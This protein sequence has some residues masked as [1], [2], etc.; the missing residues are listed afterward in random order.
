MGI[1]QSVTIYDPKK[2]PVEFNNKIRAEAK[3]AFSYAFGEWR[4][5][6]L[7]ISLGDTFEPGTFTP[8]ARQCL[9]WFH[10]RGSQMFLSHRRGTFGF[11]S[12]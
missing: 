12:P 11:C 9:L 5:H 3:Q 7:H 4:E 1:P 6:K 10:E 8:M 2:H